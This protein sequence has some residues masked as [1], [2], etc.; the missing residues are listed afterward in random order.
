MLLSHYQ[1][2]KETVLPIISMFKRKTVTSNL[3]RLQAGS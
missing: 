2:A 3:S 1:V